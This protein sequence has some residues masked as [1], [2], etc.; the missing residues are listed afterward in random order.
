VRA[1]SFFLVGLVLPSTPFPSSLEL[2]P[3]PLIPFQRPGRSRLCSKHQRYRRHTFLLLVWSLARWERDVPLVTVDC[4]S[5]RVVPFYCCRFHL[6]RLPSKRVVSVF[7][8]VVCPRKGVVSVAVSVYVAVSVSVYVVVFRLR[9]A[10]GLPLKWAVF[11]FVVFCV[12]ILDNVE[13]HC[14]LIRIVQ[15]GGPRARIRS[16]YSV[17]SAVALRYRRRTQ[18]V[19][20]CRTSAVFSR[21]N[22]DSVKSRKPDTNTYRQ[23]FSSTTF[24]TITLS[25]VTLSTDTLSTV[26]LSTVTHTITHTSTKEGWQLF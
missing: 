22:Q 8:S 2:R 20:T 26:T 21:G 9:S 4:S 3:F 17:Y 13:K 15:S 10:R 12:F 25:T 6:R 5:C 16:I 11:V 24:S 7:V 14:V 23:R 19:S 1:P 18:T